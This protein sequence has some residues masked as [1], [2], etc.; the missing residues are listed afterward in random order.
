M[1]LQH[2]HIKL[3]HRFVKVMRRPKKNRTEPKSSR[4]IFVWHLLQH[5]CVSFFAA[6]QCRTI[7]TFRGGCEKRCAACGP[8]EWTMA[9]WRQW[10]GLL[11]VRAPIQPADIVIIWASWM[12]LINILIIGRRNIVNKIIYWAPF[13]FFRHSLTLLVRNGPFGEEW[14]TWRPFV[15]SAARRHSGK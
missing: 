12:G 11:Q 3:R 8:K 15:N 13:A 7:G 10:M 4:L 14:T 5:I 9:D 2:F 1:F 6:I